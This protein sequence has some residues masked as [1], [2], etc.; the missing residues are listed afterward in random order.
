PARLR[1]AGGLTGRTARGVAP[2]VRGARIPGIGISY[3]AGKAIRRL[4]ERGTPRLHIRTTNRTFQSTSY[5]VIGEVTGS[6]YPNEVVLIGGHYDGHDVAQ[7]A[8]DDGA[9]TI[10]GLEAGRALAG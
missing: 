2:E 3:E 7:G 1:L 6:E 4:A 8:G 5:N 10:T 9:G